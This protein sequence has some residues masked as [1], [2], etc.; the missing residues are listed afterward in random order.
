MDSFFFHPVIAT[1]EI[2]REVI[3]K[4]L[5]VCKMHALGSIFCITVGGLVLVLRHRLTRD[6]PSEGYTFDIQDWAARGGR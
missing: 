5:N 4:E 3:R 2:H 6:I 1:S